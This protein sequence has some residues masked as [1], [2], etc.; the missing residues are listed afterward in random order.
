VSLAPALP[1]AKDRPEQRCSRVAPCSERVKAQRTLVCRAGV[2]L[3]GVDVEERGVEVDRDVARR[4]GPPDHLACCCHSC[5]DPAQ[6]EEAAA[7]TALQAVETE[8]TSP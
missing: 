7:L 3:F 2:L 4:S 5:S 1:G 8:A 6:L